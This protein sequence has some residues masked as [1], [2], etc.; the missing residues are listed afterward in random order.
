MIGFIVNID[1]FTEDNSDFRHVLYTGRNLQLVLM[2]LAPG[3]DIGEEVH[4]THDQFF[5]IK[6][7]EGRVVNN[8]VTSNIESDFAVI[9]P[10]V[11]RHNIVYTGGK[12]M[13]LCTLYAPPQHKDGF[14][15]A[16]RALAEASLEK[17]DG[18]TSE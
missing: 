17:L 14:V 1:R 4:L 13:R 3:E 12:P 5:R 15:A 11:A 10:A 9:V 8:G 7:G 2:P 16:A 18:V 6:A